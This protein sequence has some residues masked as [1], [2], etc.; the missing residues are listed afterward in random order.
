MSGET[1]NSIIFR[2]P[3]LISTVAAIPGV[4]FTVL[5]STFIVVLFRSPARHKIAG[6]VP[7]MHPHAPDRARLG[8]LGSAVIA[9]PDRV[10]A[11]GLDLAR[12]GAVAGEGE[13]VEL[14]HGVLG[15]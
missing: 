5:P 13:G 6:S 12:H 3:V 14:D 2:F 10:L 4:K 8:E 11:D 9:A 1:R 15:G 7:M